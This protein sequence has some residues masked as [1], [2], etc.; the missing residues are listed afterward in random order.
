MNLLVGR[1]RKLSRWDTKHLTQLD[2]SWPADKLAPLGEVAVRRI[3]SV[4]EETRQ[5]ADVQL[6]TIH[7]NGSMVPRK[8][9]PQELKGSLFLAQPGDVVFSKIDVRNGA[10]A[11][12]PD[13]LGSVAFTAE[14]PIYDVQAKAQLRPAF[15][16]LLCRTKVFKSKVNALVVGQGGRKRVSP[17]LMETLPVPIPD[18]PEQDEILNKYRELTTDARNAREEANH[19]EASIGEMFLSRLGIETREARRT[20][21]IF[22]SRFRTLQLWDTLTTS[23]GGPTEIRSSRT[24]VTRRPLIEWTTRI[25]SGGT[26]ARGN[27]AFWSGNIPWASP[28]D[29]KSH[30]ISDT[31][32]HLSEEGLKEISGGLAPKDA[33]LLVVRSMIL[34][35]T[36]PVALAGR[37]LAINQDLK[38]IVCGPDVL[39]QYLAEY[40]RATQHF[41][42][43]QVKTDNR[44]AIRNEVLEI[45][46]VVVPNNIREQEEMVKNST[47]I[48]I[49][50]GQQRVEALRLEHEALLEVER[51]F[52]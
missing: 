38:A 37:E 12:V 30:V 19:L 32:E 28:K 33:V 44:R 9:N 8:V 21:G 3:E 15:V 51:M 13:E 34:M 23:R 27:A 22:V 29:I 1:F 26:P 43:E 20:R 24:D 46:P 25:F 31:Q 6:A 48:R 7:F 45:F 10:I 52:C 49:E 4:D 16:K 50:S 17:E 35:R 11:V 14:Y 18:I 39:P 41:M 40:L 5:S 2:W 47:E 42:L 36:L